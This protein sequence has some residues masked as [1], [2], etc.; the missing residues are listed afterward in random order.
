MTFSS[1]TRLELQLAS[2]SLPAVRHPR[3]GYKYRGPDVE[4]AG[5]LLGDI[6]RSAVKDVEKLHFIYQLVMETDTSSAMTLSGW[7]S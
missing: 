1:A 7:R 2:V 6:D 4:S 5:G 3:D